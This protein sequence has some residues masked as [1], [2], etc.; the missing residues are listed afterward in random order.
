M[1]TGK[2][3]KLTP[4]EKAQRIKEIDEQRNQFE[5]ANSGD[6]KLIYPTEQPD[7]QVEYEKF[8]EVSAEHWEDFTTGRRR[9]NNQT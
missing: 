3:T 6:F 7:K 9:K 8:L 5:L 2:K 1:L 4:E